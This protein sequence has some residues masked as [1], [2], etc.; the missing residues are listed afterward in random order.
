M[1][2]YVASCLGKVVLVAFNADIETYFGNEMTVVTRTQHLFGV[3]Q[4]LHGLVLAPIEVPCE[5]ILPIQDT[6]GFF[7]DLHV[8]THELA[9]LFQ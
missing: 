3:R 4:V 2:R 5:A 7:V 1:V 8:G 9:I 6:S